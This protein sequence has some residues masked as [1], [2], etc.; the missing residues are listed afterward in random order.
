MCTYL[1]AISTGISIFVLFNNKQYTI[2]I[3]NNTNNYYLPID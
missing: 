3:L 1:E 2:I